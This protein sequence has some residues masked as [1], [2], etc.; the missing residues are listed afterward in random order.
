LLCAFRGLRIRWEV[1]EDVHRAFLSIGC[2]L[3]C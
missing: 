3:I 2:T 1:R